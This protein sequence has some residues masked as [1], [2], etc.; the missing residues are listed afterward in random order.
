MIFRQRPKSGA[1]PFLPA[2][3]KIHHRALKVIYRMFKILIIDP[4]T[5]FRKSLK[6]S[7]NSQFPAAELRD[8]ATGE[9]GLKQMDNFAPHLIFMDLYLPDIGG[10]YLSKKI[11]EYHSEIILAIFVGYDSPEYQAAANECGVAHLIPKDD[12]TVKDILALVEAVSSG[13]Q[14]SHLK[15]AENDHS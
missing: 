5:A 14:I 2:T 13:T 12:W 7:L 11:S 3:F 1:E 4:N 10:L 6:K 8:T 15:K 9:E